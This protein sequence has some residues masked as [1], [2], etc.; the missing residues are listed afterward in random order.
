MTDKKAEKS[1]FRQL[2]LPPWQLTRFES[3]KGSE[4]VCF[5]INT[6]KFIDDVYSLGK[7]DQVF[8]LIAAWIAGAFLLLWAG[9]WWAWWRT[10]WW[11][12]WWTASSWL[13][14]KRGTVWL[15]LEVL[16]LHDFTEWWDKFLVMGAEW[17]LLGISTAVSWQAGAANASDRG[18]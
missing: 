5:W 17:R 12:R 13:H 14:M 16:E 10:R 6:R 1:F 7:F 2:I 4:N 11:T 3:E 8:I 9:F 15:E 18:F